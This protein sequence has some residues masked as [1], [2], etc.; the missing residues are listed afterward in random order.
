MWRGTTL[1]PFFYANPIFRSCKTTFRSLSLNLALQHQEGGPQFIRQPH[2]PY[3][4]RNMPMSLR[5]QRFFSALHVPNTPRVLDRYRSTVFCAQYSADADMF[6]TA[7]QDR[8][9]RIYNTRTWRVTKRI[10]TQDMGWAV[11]CTDFSPNKQWVAYS[12]WHN[13]VHL[14]N[15]GGEHEIHEAL[16]FMSPGSRNALFSVKFSADSRELL[17]GSKDCHVYLYD[18]ETKRRT[19]RVQAHHDDINNV[20]W[21]DE[22]SQVFFTGSDDRMIK[23]WDRRTIGDDG[24]PV[25]CLPGHLHGITYIDSRGDGRYLISNG[26]DQRI[27]LWDLRSMASRTDAPDNAQPLHGML[28]YR[29]GVPS[30]AMLHRKLEN[31]VSV[32]TYRGHAV[33]ETLIRCKFSPPRSTGQKYIYTGSLGGDVV[34]YDVLTGRIVRRLSG[35]SETVR[36]LDWHPDLQTLI[37]TGWDGRVLEWTWSSRPDG[38]LDDEEERLDEEADEAVVVEEDF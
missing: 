38:D 15:T 14:V 4:S 30:R 24:K 35:H 13:C 6:V 12:G 18:I 11:L 19:H 34:I 37:T 21:A 26:K 27:K 2:A 16:E 33:A 28:D 1:Q 22:S 7:S 32:M 17:G 25:G 20:A 3:R 23:V 31:D 5:A 10:L 36:D 8:N 29:M 9:I